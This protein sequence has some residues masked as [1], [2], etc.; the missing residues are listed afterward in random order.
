MQKVK[1]I[2]IN[3]EVLE[4]NKQNNDLKIKIQDCYDYNRLIN[5]KDENNNIFINP[6]HILYAKFKDI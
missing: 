1:L 2:L 5:V 4:F 3:G 6:N